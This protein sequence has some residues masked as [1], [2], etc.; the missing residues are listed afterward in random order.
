MKILSSGI[1][2]LFSFLIF[3]GI[4]LAIPV[5]YTIQGRVQSITDNAR[6][7]SDAG[8]SQGT[9]V[10]Y[11][12]LIDFDRQGYRRLNDGSIQTVA[13]SFFVDFI[14]GPALQPVNGGSFNGATDIAEY[15]YGSF[16]WGPESVWNMNSANNC[17][18]LDILSDP[19]QWVVGSDFGMFYNYA[20]NSTGQCSFLGGGALY[21][22]NISYPDP[23][24]VPEPGAFLL[25]GSGLLLLISSRKFLNPAEDHSNS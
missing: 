19:S 6:I 7:V 5:E 10:S 22:T 13:D 12:I 16:I 8:L 9:L 17:F 18:T 1:I 15:N 21:I 2:T 25:F 11:T 23:A 14:S 24:P 4:A 20:Y 3:Y